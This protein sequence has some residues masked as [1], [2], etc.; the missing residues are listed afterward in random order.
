NS[1]SFDENIVDGNFSLWKHANAPL[2][3][4][5]IKNLMNESF[6]FDGTDWTANTLF[7]HPGDITNEYAVLKWTAPQNDEY[8][9]E[10][11]FRDVVKD[12][13][14]TV[15][16]HIFKITKDRD[17][18]EIWSGNLNLNET[19]KE[20]A[21]NMVMPF[22]AGDELAVVVGIGDETGFGDTTATDIKITSG[23]G[24]I[25]DANA[26]YS[27]KQN[28]NGVWSYGFLP[29][30]ETP[31]LS[32]FTLFDEG[33]ESLAFKVPGRFANP[34]SSSWEN[35]L[36][37]T[38]PY[39]SVPHTAAIIDGLRNHSKDNQPV[40]LS[41]YG[42]GSAVNLFRLTRY[43]EQYEATD[44][45]D[46]R[47]YRDRYDRFM[48]DWNRWKLEDSFISPDDFFRQAIFRMADQ[49][50]I[51]I[52]TIR[53]NANVIGHSVTGTHDQGFSGEGLITI[54]RELKPGTIDAMADVFAPLRFSCFV[55][56][57]QLYR[58]DEAR[59]EAVL[60]NEDVL[61]PGDYPVRCVVVGPGNKRIFDEI[62]TLTVPKPAVGRENPFAIPVFSKK[63][64]VDGP[65]GEY[66]FYIEFQQRGAAAGG[67]E[68]FYVTDPA[69][70]P[71]VVPEIPFVIWG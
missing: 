4:A 40:F 8:T 3:P 1:G 66:H 67:L 58:G 35:G 30:G 69:D 36:A 6:L 60:I 21:F 51:G 34:G 29:R 53:A 5:V 32:C 23:K 65:T 28:P 39:Q 57:V 18:Q 41:E 31:D 15:D 20:T 13:V 16:I 26:D 59:F 17:P 9:I 46:A 48:A 37:D 62:Q 10:A 11:R 50:R 43:Y 38:H 33:R 7:L 61:K 25:Y 19:E 14:A 68:R 2:M 47:H 55:E 44:A 24:V 56:P 27:F 52:N 63:F 54:F 70:F 45:E 22:A 42:I 64:P 12:G 49:R 71:R